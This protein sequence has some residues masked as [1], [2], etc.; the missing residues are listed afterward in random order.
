MSRET[1]ERRVFRLIK[2]YNITTEKYEEKEKT[3]FE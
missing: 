1:R 3:D 2:K